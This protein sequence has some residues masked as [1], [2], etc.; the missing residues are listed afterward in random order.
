MYLTPVKFERP[1]ATDESLR[2]SMSLKNIM[3]ILWRSEKKLISD[4]Q[5]ERRKVFDKGLILIKNIFKHLK[6]KE[7]IT[8]F[9]SLT[10]K[11]R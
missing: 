5:L 3:K 9:V 2:A 10:Q 4:I 7:G 6:T 1:K 8:F 11:L